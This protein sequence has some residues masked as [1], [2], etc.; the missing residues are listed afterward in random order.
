VRLQRA[1]VVAIALLLL[2]AGGSQRATAQGRGQG[3]IVI[4]DDAPVYA[5]A[6]G[7]KI[8]AKAPRGYSVAGITTIAG[9]VISYM[10][11]IDNGRA[12]ILYLNIRTMKGVR[13]DLKGIGENEKKSRERAFMNPD[14][15]AFFTYECGCGEKGA[16]C[17]PIQLAGWMSERW[18][19]CY[20]EARDR[21]LAELKAQWGK[22]GPSAAQAP[23]GSPER[24]RGAEKAL[25]NA[26]VVAL[27]KVGLDDAL[28]TSKVQQAKAVVFDL[29]TD[30]IVALKKAGASNAVIDA[31]MKRAE[32]Q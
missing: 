13:Q 19:A 15:L 24:D 3:A 26:D 12:H 29:S 8:E 7:E 14:D 16:P 9:S 32:K 6:K 28:I 30:G 31:M 1:D 2:A 10:A 23:G 18:N 4:R 21:K 27:M 22:E 11:E 5:N 25:T 17:E 20:V